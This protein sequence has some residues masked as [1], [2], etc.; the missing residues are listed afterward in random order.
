M[1]R[2][3]TLTLVSLLIFHLG[4]ATRYSLHSVGITR[5]LTDEEFGSIRDALKDEAF[6]K[7]LQSR[8]NTKLPVAKL[9][10]IVGFD[11]INPTEN[12]VGG[13]FSV[14]VEWI[15]KGE[16]PDSAVVGRNLKEML[17]ELCSPE[18]SI[19]ASTVKR[20]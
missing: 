14:Y 7:R 6:Y 5:E 2:I 1:A 18:I 12:Q 8:L 3:A 13:R 19:W 16:A 11:Q 4:C 10:E 15:G 20:N 9:M 17:N